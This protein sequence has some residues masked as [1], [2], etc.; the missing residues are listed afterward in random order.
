[1]AQEDP[2]QALLAITNMIH[3]V[4]PTRGTAKYLLKS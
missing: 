1:M 4:S 3:L 2:V